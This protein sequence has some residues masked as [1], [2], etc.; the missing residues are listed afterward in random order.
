N[1]EGLDSEA[2][3]RVMALENRLKELKAEVIQIH[4][5]I[6]IKPHQQALL[7]RLL[8]LERLP[9][10]NEP[11]SNPPP[12]S[13][14]GDVIEVDDSSGWMT[15]NVGSEDGLAKEHTLEV[16]RL[17]PRPM[18]VGML[19]IYEARLHDAVGKLSGPGGRGRVQIGDTVASELPSQE[20]P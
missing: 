17:K 3:R 5:E 7:A 4:I 19:R 8:E 20:E 18:Y 1:N 6:D 12:V 15:V 11:K 13:V 10:Q 16:Y 14:K 9:R 2:A